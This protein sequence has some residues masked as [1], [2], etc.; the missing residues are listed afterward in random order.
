MGTPTLICK[1]SFNSGRC[2]LHVCLQALLPSLSLPPPPPPP[3]NKKK[4][5]RK[6]KEINALQKISNWDRFSFVKET[7]DQTLLVN[8]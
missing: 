1:C 7:V 6:S 3:N 2:L 5:K 8:H 4:R